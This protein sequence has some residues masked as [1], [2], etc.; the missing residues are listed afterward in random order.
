MK[1]QHKKQKKKIKDQEMQMWQKKSAHGNLSICVRIRKEEH[2][3]GLRRR[4]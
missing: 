1:K 2:K 4:R 3:K